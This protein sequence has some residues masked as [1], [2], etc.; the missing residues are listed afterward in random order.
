[1]SINKIT[2]KQ[3]TKRQL[4]RIRR[5]AIEIFLSPYSSPEQVEW[6]IE[7]YPE[8]IAEVMESGQIWRKAKGEQP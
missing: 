6:A 3:P 8:G 5:R 1:M 4:E 7:V 2:G